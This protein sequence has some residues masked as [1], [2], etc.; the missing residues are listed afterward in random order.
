MGLIQAQIAELGRQVAAQATQISRLNKEVRELRARLLPEMFERFA[1]LPPELC[2]LI[3]RYALPGPRLIMVVSANPSPGSGLLYI[4]RCDGLGP[5]HTPGFSKLEE[6]PRGP[7][8]SLF[9]ACRESRRLALESYEF[10]F[11]TRISST[12][13]VTEECHSSPLFPRHAELMLP[14][15]LHRA[16]A[17]DI[18]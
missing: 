13:L 17:Q 8:P 5:R 1:Q 4:D 15:S 10:C 18:M 6:Q 2:R 3:W 14:P 12:S 11:N 9:H 7:P 16:E